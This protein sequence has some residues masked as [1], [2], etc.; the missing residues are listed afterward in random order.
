MRTGD[1]VEGLGVYAS[2]CCGHEAIFEQEDWFP[3]CPECQRLCKWKLVASVMTM[4][5]TGETDEDAA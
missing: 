4:G 5:E 1:S 3:R 2:D